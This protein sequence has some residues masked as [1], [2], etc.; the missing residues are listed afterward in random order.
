MGDEGRVVQRA[1]GSHVDKPGSLLQWRGRALLLHAAF[2]RSLCA[3]QPLLLSLRR[4]IGLLVDDLRMHGGW[5]RGRGGVRAR[6]GGR[7]GWGGYGEVGRGGVL[8]V[9]TKRGGAALRWKEEPPHCVG[10]VR[11]DGATHSRGG[12][13]EDGGVGAGRGK[14][15]GGMR[16]EAVEEMLCV[17]WCG[18]V[19][20]VL[21][22]VWV[23]VS[24]VCE[25]LLGLYDGALHLAVVLQPRALIEQRSRVQRLLQPHVPAQ[26]THREREGRRRDVGE[27]DRARRSR[28]RTDARRERAGWRGWGADLP[29]AQLSCSLSILRYSVLTR[30]V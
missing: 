26:R 22:G 17:V 7:G 16:G 3:L 20:C 15:G 8:W 10:T 23:W 21:T 30:R 12:E 6:E 9:L 4:M 18:V 19:C 29:M 1:G 5:G 28:E 24:V 13:G 11:G 25:P 27:G 2:N 14:W